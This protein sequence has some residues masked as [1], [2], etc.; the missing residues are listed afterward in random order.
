MASARSGFLGSRSRA[1]MT[2]LLIVALACAVFWGCHQNS[3]LPVDSRIG[4]VLYFGIETSFHGFDVLGTS[5]FINPPMA[6]LN[7]LIQEPLFRM[8]TNG[9]L[10]PVLG[11]GATASQ[12]GAH[13]EV[14]LRRGVQF[15][16]GTPFNADAVV[17]HW[18]RILDPANRYRGRPTFQ[19]IRSVEKIDGFTVR[20]Y[21]SHPWPAFLK[22]LSD[23]LLLF[24]FIPSPSTLYAGTD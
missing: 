6:P 7:N 11:L 1:S 10:V 3:G 16:D 24:N 22:I 12:D 18:T 14:Q 23:E 17:H 4:G 9:N 15:H 5:G 2:G 21:L 19:P 8:D 13:W 20:F